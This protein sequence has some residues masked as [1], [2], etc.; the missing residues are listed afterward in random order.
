[1]EDVPIAAAQ[2][3][4]FHEGR[5][6]LSVAHLLIALVGMF[7]VLPFADTIPYGRLAEASIFTVVLLCAVNA[8][9][10]RRRTLIAAALLVSPALVT[11]WI[12]HFYPDLLPVWPSLVA[13]V[14]FVTFVIWHLLRFVMSTPKVTSEVL[15]AAISIYLLFAVA[16][17]YLYILLA[18]SHP[19]AFKFTIAGQAQGAITGFTAIYFS[20]EILTALAFGDIVPVS[21]VARMMTLVE[22]TCAVFY[23]TILIARLVAVYSHPNSQQNPDHERS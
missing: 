21:N 1:M 2:K 9:G 4:S 8:I 13:V 10:R 5:H 20:A 18:A 6:R 11:R 15:C 3:S 23:V 22:A 16:W 12:D 14:V 7:V 17:A 19:E